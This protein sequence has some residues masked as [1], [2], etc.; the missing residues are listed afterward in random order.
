MLLFGGDGTGGLFWF[1]LHK[2]AHFLVEF[3]GKRQQKG[4]WIDGNGFPEVFQRG[5]YSAKSTRH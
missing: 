5:Y 4:R 2:S 3:P 1:L